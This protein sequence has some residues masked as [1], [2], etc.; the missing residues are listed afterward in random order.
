MLLCYQHVI[1][2][3]CSRYTKCTALHNLYTL[4][5]CYILTK[6]ICTLK[7]PLAVS[8]LHFLLVL[9]QTSLLCCLWLLD[10]TSVCAFEEHSNIPPHVSR[11][12]VRRP[13][14]IIRYRI[15]YTYIIYIA[16]ACLHANIYTRLICFYHS[17]VRSVQF[18]YCAIDR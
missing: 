15:V 18:P 4:C 2:I 16:L 12:L 8:W 1:H 7:I 3:H 13:P 14:C 11:Q 5:L 6:L 9:P 10:W 17:R